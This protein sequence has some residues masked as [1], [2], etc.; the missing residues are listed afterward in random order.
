M[1]KNLTDAIK[2]NVLIEK[3]KGA[4]LGNIVVTIRD[5]KTH[6][7]IWC[8]KNGEFYGSFRNVKWEVDQDIELTA[9]LEALREVLK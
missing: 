2:A 4:I 7:V 8:C 6:E 1:G 9:V 5:S 3:L